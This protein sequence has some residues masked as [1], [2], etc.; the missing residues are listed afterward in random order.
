[1]ELR[2]PAGRER[3]A[4]KS[5]VSVVR[6]IVEGPGGRRPHPSPTAQTPEGFRAITDV[7][8]NDV[9]VVGYPKS[10]NT[11]VQ[12]LLAA[13]VYGVDLDVCP[14]SLVQDLVPD[15]HFKKFYKR[16]SSPVFFK[17]HA[18]PTPAYRRVVYLV[19]DGRDTMVSYWH[20]LQAVQDKPLDFLH[21]VETG[22]GLLRVQG[23]NARIGCKWHEHVQQWLGNPFRAEL[24]IVRY[25]D[26]QKDAVKELQR[27]CDFA[28]LHRD[29]AGLA[30]ACAK[31][32]FAAMQTRERRFGWDNAQWPKDKRFVRR[33]AVG[34]H[35]DEMPVEVQRAF[36]AQAGATLRRL[37][38]EA[39]TR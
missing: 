38:Y 34:S 13:A 11:W 6:R 1:M 16:Y 19:R 7:A 4:V 37:G 14:D 32:S 9:F 10:G 23:G 22:D 21:L 26:L 5:I 12:S 36:L 28:E 39:V 24:I 2:R 27:I 15:V 20:H 8:E 30:T 17:S 29:P 31:A 35:A 3:R 18:L 33:G 25:E